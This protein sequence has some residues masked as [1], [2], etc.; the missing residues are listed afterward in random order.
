MSNF[1]N[2]LTTDRFVSEF[3]NSVTGTYLSVEGRT[4]M[5]EIGIWCLEFSIVKSDPQTGRQ[6]ACQI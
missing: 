4:P 3:G 2:R 6:A 5:E 1:P